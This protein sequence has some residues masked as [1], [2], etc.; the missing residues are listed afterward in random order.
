MIGSDRK[1]D[2]PIQSSRSDQV[3]PTPVLKSEIV[4]NRRLFGVLELF[5]RW[6]NK[7]SPQ[8]IDMLPL[9]DMCKFELNLIY[10]LGGDSFCSLENVL[11]LRYCTYL[12]NDQK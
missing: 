8:K 4:K 6:I 5:S 9:R 7:S 3:M 1:K 2:D 11:L 10:R 12:C